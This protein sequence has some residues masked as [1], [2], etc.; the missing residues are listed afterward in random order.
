MIKTTVFFWWGRSHRLWCPCS[1]RYSD[2]SDWYVSMGPWAVHR[3]YCSS[4]I[5]DSPKMKNSNKSCDQEKLLSVTG[6]FLGQNG[7]S[8]LPKHFFARA[9]SNHAVGLLSEW[10]AAGR[11]VN[12]RTSQLRIDQTRKHAYQ[13]QCFP[14]HYNRVKSDHPSPCNLPP[15][16]SDARAGTEALP[17]CTHTF[18]HTVSLAP[19]P[20]CQQLFSA[21]ARQSSDA[22]ARL[23]Q[24]WCAHTGEH[25]SVLN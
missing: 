19:P 9:P 1:T 21:R 5:T 24:R 23:A 11:S 8:V 2:I 10:S 14:Y 3:P 16:Q 18:A 25:T 17:W 13:L 6:F 20:P 4:T 22:G 12:S 15:P 7:S